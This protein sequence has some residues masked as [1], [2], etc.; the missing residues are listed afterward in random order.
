M[1]KRSVEMGVSKVDEHVPEILKD[2]VTLTSLDEAIDFFS[3]LLNP[4]V[5]WARSNS[6][7]PLFRYEFSAA[8]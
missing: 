2:S 7:W 6:V 1:E 3:V 8:A 4:V 5:N